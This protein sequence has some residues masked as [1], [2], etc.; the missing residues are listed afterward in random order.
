M[1]SNYCHVKYQCL[2]AS[3]GIA[4]RI[5]RILRTEREGHM[6]RKLKEDGHLQAKERC[7]E[8]TLP[9]GPQ[10]KPNLPIPLS[11]TSS[12]HNQKELYLK[13]EDKAK[14]EQKFDHWEETT[15]HSTSC[16]PS[17]QLSLLK[18][19]NFRSN[20]NKMA[21]YEVPHLCTLPNLPTIIWHPSMG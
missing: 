6:K 1:S 17:C 19:T 8:Q 10:D 16:Q 18:T 3:Y 12:L 13:K 5:H 2:S 7:L 21:E 9:C 14:R 11:W 15:E 20:V 4:L